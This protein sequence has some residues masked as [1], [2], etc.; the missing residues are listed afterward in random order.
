M[1]HAVMTDS[2][3]IPSSPT[4]VVTG[5]TRGLGLETCR[6]IAEHSPGAH[7]VLLGRAGSAMDAVASEMRDRV[8]SVATAAV[9]FADLSQVRAVARQVRDM[10]DDGTCGMI[11]GLVLNAGIQTVDRLQHTVDGVELTFGVNVVA[12]FL[13]TRELTDC[14]A[15]DASVVLVGSGTHFTDRS[16]RLVAHPRWEDPADLAQAGLG[17]DASSKVAG[18]RAYATSKLAVNH[19]C[20]ELDRR[21]GGRWRCN[22]HDPGLMPGTGLA[23]DMNGLR[24]FAWHHLLAHLPIP[25]MS[26]PQ[27]SGAVLAEMALGLR[28][29]ELR[30]GYVDIDRVTRASDESYDPAR[31]ARLWEVLEALTR[32]VRST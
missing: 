22:V 20:H 23:R 27:R 30:A 17:A 18:Q 24:R 8:R 7:V 10:I 25:G 1:H 5:P 32:A 3:I 11:D 9:D 19:L 14:L 26:T 13:L 31:E 16:T 6:A 4:V 2:D 29:A 21:S 15:P 28:F 12:P